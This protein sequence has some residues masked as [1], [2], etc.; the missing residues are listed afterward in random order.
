[1][2]RMTFYDAAGSPVINEDGYAAIEWTYNVWGKANQ[3]TYYGLDGNPVE[4]GQGCARVTYE[5]DAAGALVRSACFDL[6]GQ[7]VVWQSDGG[8]TD[9]REEASF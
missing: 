8:V 3:E 9:S 1:M 7:E 5:Y 2:T 6:D 4:S